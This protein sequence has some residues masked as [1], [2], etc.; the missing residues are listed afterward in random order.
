MREDKTKYFRGDEV[1]L[2]A[3]KKASVKD[4]GAATN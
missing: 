1:R 2:Y 3:E 4:K